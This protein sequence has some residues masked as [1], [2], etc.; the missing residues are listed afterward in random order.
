VRV[1][2]MCNGLRFWA[3]VAVHSVAVVV[4]C[5]GVLN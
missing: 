5:F 4:M 1:F 3:R 2:L